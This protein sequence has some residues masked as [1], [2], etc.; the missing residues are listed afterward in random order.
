MRGALLVTASLALLALPASANAA[1]W[2]QA[3]GSQIYVS[4]VGPNPDDVV[5][6]S[7]EGVGPAAVYVFSDPAG[8]TVTSPCVLRSPTEGQCPAE[9]RTKMTVEL[10]N[11]KNRFTPLLSDAGE[12]FAL[13]YVSVNG[14]R[15]RD[16]VNLR[17]LPA[18]VRFA[19]V[20]GGNGPDVIFAGPAKIDR[21]NGAFGDDRLIGAA[22]RD[23]QV[24]GPDDD[25][26][27]GRGG[28]DRQTGGTGRDRLNGGAGPDVLD[29]GSGADLLI[30]GTGFDQLL[31]GGGF[32]RAQAPVT[33]AEQRRAR[34]VE[35]FP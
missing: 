11:G 13:R 6:V 32:D 30:G 26:L 7:G 2:L 15:E 12:G 1:L 34:S 4:A 22:G 33:T 17:G 14:G 9:G 24:G 5:T 31:G 19:Q 23:V 27:I 3:P 25:V 29:A 10:G 8:M 35:R 18:G 16:V 21:M 28:R 20:L